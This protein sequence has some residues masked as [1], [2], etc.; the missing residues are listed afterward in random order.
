M[1]GYLHTLAR[2]ALG[3]PAP[4]QPRL[5]S[6][7]EPDAVAPWAEVAAGV[8]DRTR[9][10]PPPT[11]LGLEAVAPRAAVDDL[12]RVRA[13][14]G[15]PASGD[16]ASGDPA[17]AAVAPWAASDASPQ[18]AASDE[19][20]LAAEATQAAVDHAPRAD[21]VARGA[22]RAWSD[23]ADRPSRAPEQILL[24]S[25][26]ARRASDHAHVTGWSGADEI[27][28]AAAGPQPT[29]ET[30]NVAQP[31]VTTAAP[32][33]GAPTASSPQAGPPTA[34]Q[35]VA[36]RPAVRR[37]TSRGPATPVSER[38]P[39]AV[40]PPLGP[41]HQNALT[42]TGELSAPPSTVRPA[43]GSILQ[44]PDPPQAARRRALTPDPAPAVRG[45]P[46][47]PPVPILRPGPV[48]RRAS[49]LAAAEQPVPPAPSVTVTIGRIEVRATGGR[50]PTTTTAVT[51]EQRAE[52]RAVNLQE[53]LRQRTRGG[54]T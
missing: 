23:A 53:Y 16:P 54:R 24:A 4:V 21:D 30:V 5:R 13:C 50:P 28:R 37:A 14:A 31:I 18:R 6:L 29:A 45:A 36:T 1:N 9:A 19:S 39:T 51:P 42:P 17:S 33:A 41:S 46:P 43:A 12:A 25:S 52:Q 8:E 40:P 34:S 47:D 20:P 11:H 22:D 27:R 38:Q 15:D 32:R 3:E 2:R 10:A 48:P 7:F 26:A 49:A 35:E 44:L